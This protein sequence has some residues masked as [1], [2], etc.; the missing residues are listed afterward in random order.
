M[1]P[2]ALAHRGCGPKVRNMGQRRQKSKMT[3]VQFAYLIT[4]TYYHQRIEIVN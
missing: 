3:V 2:G 4:G 1:T